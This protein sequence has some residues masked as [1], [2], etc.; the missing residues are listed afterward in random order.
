MIIH[1]SPKIIQ[2]GKKSLFNKW[3]W[4]KWLSMCKIILK[5]LYP[6]LIPY[7][8]VNPKLMIG[9]NIRAKSTKILQGNICKSLDL[10]QQ[11]HNDERIDCC[12]SKFK[13][14]CFKDTIKKVKRKPT[15][16]E[17]NTSHIIGK[18]IA[19]RIHRVY[20]KNSV[21]DYEFAHAQNLGEAEERDGL[22]QFDR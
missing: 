22:L 19:P 3:H 1:K 7:T 14:L 2:R 6:Y 20:S 21:L 9:L 5:Q 13:I 11:E 10:W 15:K 4:K 8:K 16:Q 17:K 12:W 18:K